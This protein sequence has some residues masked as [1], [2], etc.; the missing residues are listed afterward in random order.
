MSLPDIVVD[1]GA[2]RQVPITRRGALGRLFTL[3]A[4]ATAALALPSPA[5]AAPLAI[6][7]AVTPMPDWLTDG[8]EWL[9][10]I[11]ERMAR[12]LPRVEVLITKDG[13]PRAEAP[14]TPEVSAEALAEWC[15]QQADPSADTS[16]FL[17]KLDHRKARTADR[18][19]LKTVN[20]ERIVTIR[21][22]KLDRNARRR[23]YRWINRRPIGPEHPLVRLRLGQWW[24]EKERGSDFLVVAAPELGALKLGTPADWA[25]TLYAELR[26][27]IRIDSRSPGPCG[28][29]RVLCSHQGSYHGMS[30]HPDGTPVY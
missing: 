16:L 19:R 2:G 30:L 27:A 1:A 22:A 12:T 6:A 18:P 14:S 8:P 24:N 25:T 28:A 10:A 4:G 3:G 9:P 17:F 20:D 15:E 7:P 21:F 5:Q 29:H 13:E 11:L 26:D 23:A